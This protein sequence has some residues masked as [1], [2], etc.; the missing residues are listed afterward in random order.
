MMHMKVINLPE[1]CVFALGWLLLTFHCEVSKASVIELNEEQ[2]HYLLGKRLQ[3]LEDPSGDLSI[4]NIAS[5]ELQNRFVNATKSVPNFGFTSSVYWIRFTLHNRSQSNGEWYL[6]QHFANTHYLDLYTQDSTGHSYQVKKSGNLRPVETR[7]IDDR[8]IGFMLTLNS[9]EVKTYYLRV[10]NS[11]AMT[12]DLRL[13]KPAAFWGAAK[14]DATL[15]GIYFGVIVITL[16]YYVVLF[17]YLGDKSTLWLAAFLGSMIAVVGFYNGYA[18]MLFSANWIQYSRYGLPLA[19]SLTGIN[20]MQFTRFFLPL[21]AANI[22]IMRAHDILLGLNLLWLLSV[23]FTSYLAQALFF[24]PII[25]GTLIYC[26]YRVIFCLRKNEA[27]A[28]YYLLGWVALIVSISLTVLVRYDIIASNYFSEYSYLFSTVWMALF[29]SI[30]LA[31]RIYQLKQYA[32]KNSKA[33][34]QSESQRLAILNAGKLGVWSWNI[35]DNSVKWSAETEAIFG[36]RLGEFDGRFETYRKRIANV[37]LSRVEN[38]IKNTLATQSP[39]NIEHRIVWP[40]GRERWINA[41]GKIELDDHNNPVTLSGTVQDITEFKQTLE[42]LHDTEQNFRDLFNSAADG[43]VIRTLDGKAVE[44]NPAVCAM[45]GYS[46]QEYLRLPMDKI[47]HPKSMSLYV[48]FK[49]SMIQGKPIYSDDARGIRKDG[50]TFY[51][52]VR[53][54]IIQ[55]RGKPHLF[56]VL[57]DV[58]DQRRLQMAIKSIASGVADMT[59]VEFFRQLVLCLTDAYEAKYAF[60]GV[61]DDSHPNTIRTLA[62]CEGNKLLDNIEYEI[63]G[64]PSAKVVGQTECN[65]EKDVVEL[66]PQDKLLAQLSV[67]SFVGAPMFD[68]HGNALGLIVVM[69]DKPRPNIASPNE[70]TKIVALRAA[71]EFERMKTENLIKHHQDQLEEQVAERT[72][73]LKAVNRELE[74]FSYSVSHDLR[75]PLRSIDGFS[76]ILLEDYGNLLDEEGGEYLQRIRA[77]AQR[78]AKLID[79]LLELSR[80]TRNDIVKQPINLS[81]L[82]EDSISK[83]KEQDRSREVSVT[84]APNMKIYGDRDML[85]IAIDNLVANS[86]KYTRKSYK[87]NIEF[88]EVKKQGKVYYYI[89]DNGVG[90]DMQYADKLFHAFQRLHSPEDFEGTGI[91]LATVAR[92]IHRHGGDIWV[93]AQ[94]DKGATFYFDLHTHPG[95]TTQH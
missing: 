82:V 77:A 63:A 49:E 59:G 72:A 34:H 79:D 70:V 76:Q 94:P 43:F 91:G 2:A 66:F 18:Q 93:D 74:S 95:N 71:T 53:G 44:A 80:V 10:Q 13:W 83:C 16:I 24:L 7:D 51:L 50:S 56:F 86:W 41:Y 11:A 87:P 73:E 33:L 1:V 27:A 9:D 85:S 22:T 58:T 67:Q 68:T 46:K 32:E 12:I 57:R 5:A 45:Y 19:L 14:T 48:K 29:M 75:A 52:Q 38:E 62:F 69:D 25:F 30:A 92:I 60:I 15:F 78:M 47:V 31:Q 61:L 28:K 90:F 64:T 39:F 3:F 42:E 84:I 54:N 26:V 17:L 35:A 6:I 20:L 88:G 40:D 4:E 81:K 89:K 55:Y 37:D 23:P 8:H 65:Y 36:L 21:P